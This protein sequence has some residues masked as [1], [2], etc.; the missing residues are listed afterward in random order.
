MI[1]K[2]DSSELV[3][4]MIGYYYD[5]IAAP[6]EHNAMEKYFVKEKVENQSS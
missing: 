6:K 2:S 5:E 4:D 3:Y 1:H